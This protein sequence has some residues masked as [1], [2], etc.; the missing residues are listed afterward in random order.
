MR[1]RFSTALIDTHGRRHN[2]LRISLTEKCNLR[3]QYCMPAEGV[4]LSPHIITQPEIMRLATLFKSLGVEKIRLT[5]GEPTVRQD[6]VEIVRS[7]KSSLFNE[8]GM[9]TNGTLLKRKLPLLKEAG[10]THL[11][12]SLD[13]L[14]P[15]KN[16]FITRRPNTTEIVLKNIE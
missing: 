6:L 1:R 11:N 4:P 2:Y 5:G 13:S 12:I 8:I 3:C 10:L 15:A 14:V 9:T 7:L 16:E